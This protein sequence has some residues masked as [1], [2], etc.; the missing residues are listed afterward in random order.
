MLLKSDKSEFELSI[1]GYQFPNAR[2]DW[3][4][5]DIRLKDYRGERKKRDPCLTVPEASELVE[6]LDNLARAHSETGVGP[7]MPDLTEPNLHITILKA[8]K[9]EI[10]LETS[11][12]FESKGRAPAF[13]HLEIT[14]SRRDLGDAVS[15]FRKELEKY[16]ARSL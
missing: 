15:D 10:K 9:T 3:L 13:D 11:F 7:G 16:P 12:I 6:W 5:V 8:T 1:A 2:D 4:L 14:V